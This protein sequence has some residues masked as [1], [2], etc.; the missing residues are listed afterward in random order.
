LFAVA[1]IRTVLI[2][3]LHA[4]LTSFTGIGFAVAR[5]SR[6]ALRILAPVLGYLVAI[7]AH[8][9][10][11]LLAS[12]GSVAIC[13]IGSVIDWLGFFGM[14]AFVLYLVWREGKIMREHLHEEVALGNMSSAQYQAAC[15]VTGQLGARFGA[16]GAGR[17]GQT[18]RFYRLC[19][20]LAFKKYQL[21]RLGPERERSAPTMIEKLR[22]EVAALSRGA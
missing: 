9:F 15:S 3:F 8:G 7:G 6:G 5:L 21:A 20:E 16:L 2:P 19:G 12:T 17:W 22:G 1:F 10:H 18:T 4:T 11:N 14:F 13:F